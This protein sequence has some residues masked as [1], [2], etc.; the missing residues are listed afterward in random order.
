MMITMPVKLMII[1]VDGA[2]WTVIK[3]NLKYLPS[4]QKIIKE[5]KSKTI[6]LK[7]EDAIISPAIWCSMFSGQPLSVHKHKKFVENGKIVTREDIP[8]KFV[9]EELNE[10][11]KVKALQVPFIIPPYNYN[12]SYDAIGFGASSDENELDQDTDN[13]TFKA[14]EIT[15]ESP[16]L[17][18]VVFNALDRIQHFHWGESDLLLSWYKKIDRA[19]GMLEKYADKLII[20]SDHGFCSKGEAREA[21]LPDKNPQGQELKGDHHEEAILITRNIN[22]EI[23]HPMDVYKTIKKEFGVE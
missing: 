1:G 16:D 11:I 14:L 21:T 4:F 7:A 10:K 18:I 8:V 17:F 13:L 19:I 22:S 5:G 9:W 6:T 2:T 15:K 3:P 20:I 12:C 23:D